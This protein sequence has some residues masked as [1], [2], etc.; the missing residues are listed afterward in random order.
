M[1]SPCF[2]KSQYVYQTGIGK[3]VR[4]ESLKNLNTFVILQNASPGSLYT[5]PH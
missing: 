5:F 3:K 1:G 4:L 2:F